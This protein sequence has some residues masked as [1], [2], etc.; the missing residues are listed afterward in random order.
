MH[1]ASFVSLASGLSLAF[2]QNATLA[3]AD[4]V[5]C[6][7]VPRSDAISD[8]DFAGLAMNE[9]FFKSITEICRAGDIPFCTTGPCSL[10]VVVNTT[11]ELMFENSPKIP[12]GGSGSVDT[13]VTTCTK[14]L[15]INGG[16]TNGFVANKGNVFSSI[17]IQRYII[18][19]ELD[20]SEGSLFFNL[21][22]DGTDLPLIL[23]QHNGEL[24][25]MFPTGRRHEVVLE[26][27]TLPPT[28]PISDAFTTLTDFGFTSSST[29][30]AITTS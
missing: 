4:Q 15:C 8:N 16:F 10:G 11:F 2:A 21:A 22:A 24:L 25:M 6:G 9:T 19:A 26:P 12:V 3:G 13:S 14:T 29:A 18:P 7:N 30:L 23:D 17:T 1:K 20:S 5:V 27:L 28:A